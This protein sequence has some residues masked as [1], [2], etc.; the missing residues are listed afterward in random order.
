MIV[1]IQ[2]KKPLIDPSCF[3]AENASIIG[4]VSIGKKSSIWYGAVVR[5]DVEKICIAE[6]TNAQDLCVLHV[7][8][9]HGLC[10]GNDVTIGHRAIVHGCDVGDRVLV[11]M[12]AIIMNG[13]N[14]GDDCIIGAG[15]LITVEMQIPPRSLVIG[16]PGKVKRELTEEEISSILRS[17]TDYAKLAAKYNNKLQAPNAKF[18]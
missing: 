3:V 8:S 2:D 14:I 15:A 9:T 11:G 1:S 13:A 16:I 4:D 6:R 18:Q 5:G 17:S 7:E 12:G 10:I